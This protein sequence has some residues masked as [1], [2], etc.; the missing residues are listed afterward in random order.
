M[1]KNLKYK[2]RRDIPKFAREYHTLSPSK[3]REI[4]L[5]KK[6]K[7]LTAQSMT[8]WFKRHPDMYAQLKAEIL[9]EELPKLEVRESIFLNGTF[10]E[11]PSVKNWIKEMKRRK[12]V[13]R[14]EKVSALKRCC[15][16]RFPRLGDGIDLVQ[17]GEWSFKHPD[18]LTLEDSMELIDLLDEYDVNTSTARL[19][20]RSFLESKGRTVGKKISGAKGR[21]FGK[22]ADLFVEKPKLL[23]IL[24]WIKGLNFE[25]YVIA[26]FMFKTGTRITST[27]NA[28]I[29]NI[30]EE[31]DYREIKVFDKGR[32]LKYPEGKP[33]DKHI[34]ADLWTEMQKIIGDRKHGKIFSFAE[35]MIKN[36]VNALY[37]SAY[38]H[39]IPELNKRI[40]MPCQFWRHMFFQHMLRATDWN[41]GAAAALGGSTVKSLEESYGKPP[42]AVVREWG[43]Q[44]IPQI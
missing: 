25:A 34:P 8:M 7:K 42:R 30:K 1:R 9:A 36:E 37:R 21:G 26:L 15:K 44:Y 6:N 12:I 27:L 2:P 18:R 14:K 29:E 32:R 41:Y 3:L 4:V 13:K 10:E 23:K 11:L 5:A 40:P 43:L 22:F 16:G 28:L 33:W 24:E 17:E 38:Q 35:Y 39:F 19:A 31:G 20:L